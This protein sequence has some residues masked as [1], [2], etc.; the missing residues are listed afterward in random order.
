[1][2]EIEQ[3]VL[4]NQPFAPFDQRKKDVERTRTQRRRLPVHEQLPTRR[5]QFEPSEAVG[6]V[7]G[8]VAPGC[9][10]PDPG[11]PI[12]EQ[13]KAGLRTE[14][15]RARESTPHGGRCSND[16]AP[17]V[18]ETIDTSGGELHASI[19]GSRFATRETLDMGVIILSQPS[20]EWNGRRLWVR[21]TGDHHEPRNEQESLGAGR[22]RRA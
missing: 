1:P 12:S 18:A 6:S 20:A 17:V 5:V 21:M 7:H 10:I 2:G 22:S 3:F 14:S 4:G 15:D 19:P 11:W 8:R 9:E 13:F 16:V